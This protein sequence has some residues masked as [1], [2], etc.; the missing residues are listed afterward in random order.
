MLETS[1]PY[2]CQLDPDDMITSDYLEKAANILENEPEVGWVTPKTLVFGGS[3]HITWFWD[4]DFIYSL[5]KC[6]SPALSVFRRSMWEDIGRYNDEMPCRE[7]WEFW[8]RAG[9]HGW[10]SRTMDDVYFM[11]RHAFRRWGELDKYNIPSKMDIFNYHPWWYKKFSEKELREIFLVCKVGE[12]PQEI[13]DPGTV[14]KVENWKSLS[15][16]EMRELVENIKSE[17]LE[18]G[19]RA[20]IE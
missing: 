16:R 9:E 18:C 8:I 19:A 7:D 3:N 4:Y 12:F 2:I 5:I 14:K 10:V 20:I 6:P 1:A 17:F 13:L 15:R 11:Y